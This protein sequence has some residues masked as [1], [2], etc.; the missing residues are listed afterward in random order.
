M[1]VPCSE[2]RG[3]LRD[4]CLG[5]DSQGRVVMAR[6][7]REA[8]AKRLGWELPS[9]SIENT[10]NET[11]S[12]ETSLK[13]ISL[14]C[15]HRQELIGTTGCGRCGE[16]D[17]EI[18]V[19]ACSEHGRCTTTRI[20]SKNPDWKLYHSCLTCAERQEP[21][22]NRLSNESIKTK[23]VAVRVLTAAS[24]VTPRR[25]R[26][27]ITTIDKSAQQIAVVNA[28]GNSAACL[29]NSWKDTGCFLVCGG[30]SLNAMD[31]TLLGQRGITIAAVNQCG[32]THVRPHIWFSVDSP[33]R[34]H[35]S[36]WLDPTVMK[37]AK[38]RYAKNTVYEKTQGQFVDTKKQLK[39]LPNMWFYEHSGSYDPATFLTQPNPT[40][41]NTRHSVMLIAIRLLYWLGMRTI[42]IVGADFH[43]SPEQ[44]YAFDDPKDHIASASNNAT[45]R[46]LN[47]IFLELRPYFADRGLSVY[48]ATP[49]GNLTAFDRVTYNE[50]VDSLKISPANDVQGYYS[51]TASAQFATTSLNKSPGDCRSDNIAATDIVN[52]FSRLRS[53]S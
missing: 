52:I 7:S 3:R 13:S 23:S 51:R 45:Y 15:I 40:W 47:E 10:Q 1:N 4:I 8:Y 50:A 14:P 41:G 24:A 26:A 42:Y 11:K 32:A 18:P 53:S 5:H 49:G 35:S 33:D 16:V 36:I 37:F 27:K 19:Y 38:R 44:T 31:L 43:M 28:I 34:F 6:S 21:R 39:T 29:E 17:I 9:E 25:A 22:V 46:W 12:P 2:L 30:P 48:N 20:G